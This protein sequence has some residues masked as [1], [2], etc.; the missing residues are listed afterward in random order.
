V[1]TGPETRTS[2]IDSAERLIAAQGFS[3]TTIKQ[4]AEAAR[5]N[6]SLLYY[7]FGDKEGLYRAVVERLLEQLIAMGTTAL[8]SEDDPVA[9]VRAIIAGQAKLLSSTPSWIRILAR[10]LLDAEHS[11]VGEPARRVASTVFAQLCATI[12]R[13]QA[14]GLFRRDL[15]PRFAAISLVGQQ[16][17]FYLAHPAVKVLLESEGASLDDETRSAFAQH[18]AEFCLAALRPAQTGAA[19]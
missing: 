11:R 10:E 7:Y 1:E 15:D 12:R 19:A 13:G 14:Q 3:A 8:S 4:I 9:A 16:A 18:V 6:T 5:V 17:Y 2:I